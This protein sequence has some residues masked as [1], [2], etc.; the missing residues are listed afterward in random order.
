MEFVAVSLTDLEGAPLCP[1]R[2]EEVY[3]TLV[4]RVNR[5]IVNPEVA[6]RLID[7]LGNLVF[8]TVIAP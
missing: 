6:F 3:L 1:S 8:C 5:G 7:R 4:V 2:W